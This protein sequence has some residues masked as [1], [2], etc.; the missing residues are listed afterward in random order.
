MIP[1]ENTLC[2]RAPT[3]SRT[4]PH[5]AA[6]PDAT[7]HAHGP[8]SPTQVVCFEPSELTRANG[9]ADATFAVIV[10]RSF[11]PFCPVERLNAN[12]S[13]SAGKPGRTRASTV[14]GPLVGPS[15]QSWTSTVLL[16]PTAIWIPLVG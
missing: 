5:K 1:P 11:S 9:T 4:A 10:R 16:W 7:E 12:A 2:A 15:L 8:T 6:P 13:A 14:H 3:P